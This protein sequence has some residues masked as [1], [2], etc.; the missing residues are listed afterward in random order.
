MPKNSARN[1]ASAAIIMV[2]FAVAIF[3]FRMMLADSP[4]PHSTPA[5]APFDA[6]APSDTR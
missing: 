3:I 6:A 4:K 1:I 2:L 5:C